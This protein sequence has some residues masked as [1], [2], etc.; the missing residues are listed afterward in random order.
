MTV[1]KKIIST[2]A[3]CHGLACSHRAH[4]A[5]SAEEVVSHLESARSLLWDYETVELVKMSAQPSESA[6]SDSPSPPI[7][8][9]PAL[10]DPLFKH[11]PRLKSNHQHSAARILRVAEFRLGKTTSMTV[12]NVGISSVT[13]AVAFSQFIHLDFAKAC[14]IDNY[15]MMGMLQQTN[16]GSISAAARA[17]AEIVTAPT[18]V[19][20]DNSDAYLQFTK[21]VKSKAQWQTMSVPGQLKLFEK[22]LASSRLIFGSLFDSREGRQWVDKYCSSVQVCVLIG[23]TNEI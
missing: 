21:L 4:L 12:R 1:L 13:S 9:P 17:M 7:R 23:V 2:A 3:G 8:S 11:F 19:E 14:E 6:V 20:L 5:A 18:A 15:S 22:I 10:L 16:D